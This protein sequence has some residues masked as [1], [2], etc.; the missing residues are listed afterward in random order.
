MSKLADQLDLSGR[1]AVVTGGSRG[2]GRAIV[3]GFAE[4]GADVV[5]ASRKLE[6][7]ELVAE[8]VAA[9]AGVRAL[10]VT[11][12]AGSW[13]DA[14]RLVDAVYAEFGRCDVLVNNAGM[15]PVYGG[16]L[17]NVTPELYDKTHNVNARGPFRLC[18]L[19]AK[20]MSAAG[21]GAPFSTS[22]RRG[23][24]AQASM[25]CPMRWPRPA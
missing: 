7:C 14:E 3:Q 9:A 25:T 23:R 2:I 24:C 5:I 4:A 8:E 17:S 11:Y 15:S 1:V 18:A 20:R 6:N 10:A 19:L 12:H 22:P 21:R 13:D 16:E